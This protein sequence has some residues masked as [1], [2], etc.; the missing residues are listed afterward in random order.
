[1]GYYIHLWLDNYFDENVENF[2][3]SK[4]NLRNFRSNVII[5][6]NMKNYDIKSI[7]NFISKITI[8][9]TPF[10]DFLPIKLNKS[11]NIFND[12]KYKCLNKNF[13]TTCPIIL[14]EDDYINFINECSDIFLNQCN[15][16]I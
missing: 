4:Y 6:E 3:L 2:F 15:F 11:I 16:K 14:H 7:V 12:F 8:I 10:T 13:S 5:N 9:E 1:M